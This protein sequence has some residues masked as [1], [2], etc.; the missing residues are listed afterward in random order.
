MCDEQALILGPH[1]ERFEKELAA[2]CGTRHAIGVSSGTDA[3]LCSLM[4]LGVGP[5]DEVVVPDLTF[6]ATINA[7]LCCGATPVIVD[8]DASTWSMSLEMIEHACSPRTKAIIPVHLYGR[9]AEMGPIATFA[10]K[11]GIAIVE[12]CA[13]AHGARYAAAPYSPSPRP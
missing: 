10:A 6:A 13:E 1:V 3:L 9:P 11:R 8:V 5:G 12:D 2:Y 7:V 4:A